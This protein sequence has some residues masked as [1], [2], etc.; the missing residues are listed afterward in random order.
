MSLPED[1]FILYSFINTQLRDKYSSFEELC[2]KNDLDME[3]ISTK[4]RTAGF[5]YSPEYNKFM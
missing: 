5:E 2:R 4:L 3:N 1:P